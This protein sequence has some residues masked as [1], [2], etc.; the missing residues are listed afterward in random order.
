MCTNPAALVEGVHSLT[1]QE[2]CLAR[3]VL[4]LANMDVIPMSRSLR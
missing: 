4:D 1:F 2:Q 3:K